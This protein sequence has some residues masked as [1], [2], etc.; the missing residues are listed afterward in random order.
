LAD[1]GGYQTRDGTIVVGEL[2]ERVIALELKI[3]E[4]QAQNEALIEKERA[5]AVVTLEKGLPEGNDQADASLLHI[6][7]E[8]LE[9]KIEASTAKVEAS[10]K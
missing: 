3:T 6:V 10:F 9:A 2:A 5:A 7:E 1:T 8:R 4:L